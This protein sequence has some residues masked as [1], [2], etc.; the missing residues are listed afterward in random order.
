LI[1]TLVA[2]TP[3][4]SGPPNPG[5]E[6]DTEVPLLPDNDHLADVSNVSDPDPASTDLAFAS[7]ES[8]SIDSL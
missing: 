4:V 8:D 7:L 6:I 5:P 1:G 3:T 2:V